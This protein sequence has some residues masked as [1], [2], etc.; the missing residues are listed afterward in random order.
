[1]S[2]GPFGPRVSRRRAGGAVD[3]I[4]P[5]FGIPGAGVVSG[6]NGDSHWL[7]RASQSASGCPAGWERA[8]PLAMKVP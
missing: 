8:N 7:R 4:D 3:D 1:M 2:W 6:Q 5:P